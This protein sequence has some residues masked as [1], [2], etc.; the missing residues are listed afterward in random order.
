LPS[1]TLY[2]CVSKRLTSAARASLSIAMRW[3]ASAVSWMV[4]FTDASFPRTVCTSRVWNATSLSNGAWLASGTES[5]TLSASSS[6]SACRTTS[7]AAGQL[8]SAS[9]AAA[10]SGSLLRSMRDMLQRAINPHQDA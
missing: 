9:T 5:R 2:S 8:V 4:C 3:C 1:F 7:S 6:S 10:L